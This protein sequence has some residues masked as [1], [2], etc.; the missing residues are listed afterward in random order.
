M[1]CQLAA[2]AYSRAGDARRSNVAGTGR[3]TFP[4]SQGVGSQRAQ[5]L[6]KYT[7]D[8][9]LHEKLPKTLPDLVVGGP[10]AEVL[11]DAPGVLGRCRGRV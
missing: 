11:A 10:I 3:A 8:R 7:F 9:A 6:R 5:R 1:R 2:F 4:G